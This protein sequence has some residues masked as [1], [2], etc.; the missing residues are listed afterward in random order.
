M[1]KD[2]CGD[3]ETNIAKRLKKLIEANQYL[4]DIESIDALLPM[5]LELAK[6]VTFAEASSIHPVLIPLAGHPDWTM[7]HPEEIH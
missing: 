3:D 6:N 7:A 4:A 5:L 2:N 1:I